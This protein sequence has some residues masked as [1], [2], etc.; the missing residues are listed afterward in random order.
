MIDREGRPVLLLGLVQ[1]GVGLT[2]LVTLPILGLLPA[3]IFFLMIRHHQSWILMQLI[4]FALIGSLL[5]LP[6]LLMGATFPLVARICARGRRDVGTVVGR[7]YA[8]NALGTIAGS[9]VAGFL[10]IPNP[11]VGTEKT[12]ILATMLNVALGMAAAL[13]SPELRPVRRI[14]TALALAGVWVGGFLLCVPKNESGERGWDIDIITSSP[15]FFYE[16]FFQGGR[17][18]DYTFR[19]YLG[20]SGRRVAYREGPFSTVVIREAK[21]GIS[22]TNDTHMIFTGGRPE[23]SDTDLQQN[24]LM[25]LGMILH[26]NPTKVCCIGLGSGSTARAA[27]YH[28]SLEHLDVVEISRAVSELSAEYF[29]EVHADLEAAG[30]NIIVAD[31]RNHLALTD[32]KY[33]VIVSQP[34]HPHLAGVASLFTRD[35]FQICK[36]RLAPGGV[37]VIWNF[38]WRIEPEMFRAYVR[39][40]QDVFPASLFMFSQ[41][42][43]T[44]LV[45]FKDDVIDLDWEV[46]RARLEACTDPVIDDDIN[47]SD[48]T[49]K[50][51]WF[52]PEHLIDL[53]TLWPRGVARFAGEGP[54]NTDDNAML[55]YALPR[56]YH[57]DESLRLRRIGRS[58]RNGLTPSWDE[59]YD[60]AI[61]EWPWEYIHNVPPDRLP[62]ALREKAG[63]ESPGGA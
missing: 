59:A 30:A 38:S 40:F 3:W 22:G 29:P 13:L 24:L 1:S 11:A 25:H 61:H 49:Q 32:Q 56:S 53:I 19:E 12:L 6:T 9:F 52:R 37:C 8:I 15:F 7:A 2:A 23:A 45:G 50:L 14:V 54:L 44:F 36:D 17:V 41:G 43:Y 57:L 4:V 10:L 62:A 39:S 63:G 46:V 5:L 27:T 55:E 34:S 16:K 28:P 47:P 33:D 18:T 48:D 31:G 58:V 26:P 42:S 51:I 35:F 60:P 21:R 20:T